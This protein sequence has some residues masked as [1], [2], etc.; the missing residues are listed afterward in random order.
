MPNHKI[1]GVDV[2]ADKGDVDWHKV[3]AAGC[4][5]AIVKATEGQGFRDKRFTKGRWDAM[6][7]AGLVRGAYHFARPSNGSSDPAG[8]AHD[9]LAAVTDVGG[10]HSGDLPLALD[11]E[12]TKLGPRDT[13]AW[14]KRFVATI[15]HATGRPPLLYTFPS[16]W[17]DQVGNPGDN[18]DCPLWI[19]HFGVAKPTVPH[20]W[21]THTIWQHSDNGSVTGI[22]GNC[23][24]DRL[25]GDTDLLN[26]VVMQ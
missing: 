6:K 20:A 22:A 19:A 17:I 10:L 3:R 25:H 2:H 8:E 9:F 12:V 11:L 13:F 14:T 24:V 23:D 5:F 7:T 1:N 21:E 26:R 18:L 15:K 4:E 16:F